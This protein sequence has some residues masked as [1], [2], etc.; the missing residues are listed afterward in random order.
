MMKA[1]NPFPSKNTEF[2]HTV[3]GEEGTRKYIHGPSKS[4]VPQIKNPYIEY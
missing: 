3:L 1:M 4:P 2:K